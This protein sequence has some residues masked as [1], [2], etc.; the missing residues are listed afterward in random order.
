[1]AMLLGREIVQVSEVSKRV[2]EELADGP[3]ADPQEFFAC[4]PAPA[5]PVA[6]LPTLPKPTGLP[7]QSTAL[8]LIDFQKDFLDEGGFAASKG[9]NVSGVA[10]ECLPGA[11]VLLQAARRA[12]A[13]GH[14]A[15]IVHT[16]EAHRPDLADL[17]H[18]KSHG[19][20]CPPKGSRIGDVL[21]AK[22]GRILID[23]SEGNEFVD[24]MKPEL[25]E[26][27]LPKPGK[28]AFFMTGLHQKLRNLG[29]SHLIVCG[30]TTEVCVQTTLREANDRG[31]ECVLVEDATASYFPAFK[32]A[33]IEMIRSQG[34]I[35]GFTVERA[36]DVAA[37]MDAPEQ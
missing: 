8:V 21:D 9:N 14:L 20:R 29:V 12:L 27:V 13:A 10:D 28:G 24:C 17:P 6:R 11:T 26:L 4:R 3:P 32:R 35:V 7:L 2:D 5:G 18:S 15:A 30:V 33:A 37:A 22:M 31:Y 16:K 36:E 1:M 23:G 34:G 25:G 19:V